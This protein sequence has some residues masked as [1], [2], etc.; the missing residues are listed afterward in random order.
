MIVF[1][2]C[3]DY[4]LNYSYVYQGR[5]PSSIFRASPQSLRFVGVGG[6]VGGWW[7]GRCVCVFKA[8]R[9]YP[10]LGTCLYMKVGSVSVGFYMRRRM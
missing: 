4:R 8:P 5:I 1:L 2:F 9:T 10:V 7:V 3:F 6:R